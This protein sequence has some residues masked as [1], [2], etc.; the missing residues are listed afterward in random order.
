MIWGGF[1]KLK[2]NVEYDDLVDTSFLH[3][4]DRPR[5]VS[6]LDRRPSLTP[7]VYPAQRVSL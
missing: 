6:S 4:S 1:Q 7:A 2:M 3:P 5:K